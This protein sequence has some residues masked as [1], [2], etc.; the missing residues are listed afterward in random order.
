MWY[1]FT[2]LLNIGV[3]TVSPAEQAYASIN[4]YRYNRKNKFY[5]HKFWTWE[6]EELEF[7]LIKMIF[8]IYQCF[9][10]GPAKFVFKE[11]DLKKLC[12]TQGVILAPQVLKTKLLEFI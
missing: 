9:L 3:E 6:A 8:F 7:L 1:V 5:L 11:W 12:E 2:S 10:E 4:C